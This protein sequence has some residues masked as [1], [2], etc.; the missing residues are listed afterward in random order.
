MRR[1]FTS[2]TKLAAWERCGGSCE[3][4]GLPIKGRPEYD[5]VLPCGLGGDASLENCAVL[6]C[7]CHSRKTHAGDGDRAKMSKADRLKRKHLGIDRPNSALA[8]RNRWTP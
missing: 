5:H 8:K 3:G 6:C 1:E 7:Q 2:K 4:C